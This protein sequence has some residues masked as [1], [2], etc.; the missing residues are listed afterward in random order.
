MSSPPNAA[1]APVNISPYDAE[2][3]FRQVR[4][5]RHDNAVITEPCGIQAQFEVLVEQHRPGTDLHDP[6]QVYWVD[7]PGEWT[8]I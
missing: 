4:I 5:V 7:R 6:A 1:T 2:A 3:R 8:G